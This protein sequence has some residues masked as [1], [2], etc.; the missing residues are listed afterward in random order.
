MLSPSCPKLDF[1]VGQGATPL[2]EVVRRARPRYIFWTGGGE[3]GFWE[4]E[5]FGWD[6]TGS[7]SEGRYTRGIKIGR[8]G[9]PPPVEGKK[10]ARVSLI[11]LLPLSFGSSSTQTLSGLSSLASRCPSLSTPSL[12]LLWSLPSLLDR[13]TRRP[14]LSL[15]PPREE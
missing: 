3:D 7:G 14:T 13:R 15:F 1:A 12:S 8:F 4:R 9:G 2:G 11:V 6:G 10:K 5:P